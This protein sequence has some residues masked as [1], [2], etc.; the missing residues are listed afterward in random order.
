MSEYYCDNCGS[1]LEERLH[2]NGDVLE[3]CESCDGEIYALTAPNKDQYRSLV[4]DS[5][6]DRDFIF[7]P[8]KCPSCSNIVKK[9]SRKTRECDNCE[10][11]YPIYD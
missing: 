6:S 10:L 3:L 1:S 8:F 7:N 11:T 4:Y 5:L 9:V 2:P